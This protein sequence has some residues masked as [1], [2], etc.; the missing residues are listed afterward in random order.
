MPAGTHSDA[1][2]SSYGHYGSKYAADYIREE[3]A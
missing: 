3:K 1:Y 2:Y